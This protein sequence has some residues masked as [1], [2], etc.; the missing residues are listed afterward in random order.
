LKPLRAPSA[1]GKHVL[2]IDEGTIAHDAEGKI[3]TL[4]TITAIKIGDPE[5][6]SLP[7]NKTIVG[8]AYNFEPSGI[9]FS[10]PVR[11]TMSYDVNELPERIKSVTLAYYNPESGWID[12]ICYSG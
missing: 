8:S 3:V 7:H 11:L 9:I 6:P 2:E 12:H 4:N 1:D 10:K 5:L